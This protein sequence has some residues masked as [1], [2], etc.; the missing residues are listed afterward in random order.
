MYHNIYRTAVEKAARSEKQ[1]EEDV[2]W[3]GRGGVCVLSRGALGDWGRSSRAFRP[4]TD[5]RGNSQLKSKPPELSPRK[6]SRPFC[7]KKCQKLCE[8][9]CSFQTRN[10]CTVSKNPKFTYPT[11][12]GGLFFPLV[13]ELSSKRR[14]Y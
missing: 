5:C 13:G 9:V 12:I 3:A 6:S 2:T 14:S 7:A 8:I 1:R 4:D 10:I 11:V